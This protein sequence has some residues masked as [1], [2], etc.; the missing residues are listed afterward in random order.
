MQFRHTLSVGDVA[1]RHSDER[2]ISVFKCGVEVGGDLLVSAQVFRGVPALRLP[3]FSPLDTS[4]APS[5][6]RNSVSKETVG[7]RTLWY[8]PARDRHRLLPADPWTGLS[9]I[10]A[11]P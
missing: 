11:A 7:R 8:V 10:P 3:S 2:R 1:E 4:L 6:C 5:R 9:L